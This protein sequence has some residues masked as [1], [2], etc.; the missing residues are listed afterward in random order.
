VNGIKTYSDA[1]TL[2]KKGTPIHVKGAILYNTN[3]KKYNIDKKYPA[4]QEGEKI[5]FTYLRLPNPFRDTVVSY[6][7]QLPDEFGLRKF[8]DYDMQFDK[9]FLEPI[10]VILDCIGWSI[11]KKSSLSD[12][13]N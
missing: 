10:K 2:Y 9:A 1:S 11:E 13:F 4:I 12:F 8:I 6:P 5:K 3:L 7:A